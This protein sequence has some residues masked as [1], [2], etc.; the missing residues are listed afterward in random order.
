[1][2]TRSENN[3]GLGFD[4]QITEIMDRLHVIRS[5]KDNHGRRISVSEGAGAYWGLRREAQRELDMMGYS[6]LREMITE[7]DCIYDDDSNV[8]VR[9]AIT[10]WENSI[11]DMNEMGYEVELYEWD[12]TV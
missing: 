9:D 4:V 12:H 7:L 6:V 3:W 8:D 1:M 10:R 11:D 5:T 2:I